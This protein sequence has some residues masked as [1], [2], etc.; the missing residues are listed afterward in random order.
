VGRL[1]RRA[2]NFVWPSWEESINWTLFLERESFAA[3]TVSI[4]LLC[5][6]M[7]L[8]LFLGCY[9]SRKVGIARVRL[10]DQLARAGEVLVSDPK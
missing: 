1:L 8:R 4:L 3:L 6:A 9:C 2:L 5:F 7:A 10:R